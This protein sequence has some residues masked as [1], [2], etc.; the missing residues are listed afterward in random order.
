MHDGTLLW[1]RRAV[2]N[3]SSPDPPQAVLKTRANLK[4]VME[5]DQSGTRH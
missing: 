2:F 3:R 5:T 4:N 1:E